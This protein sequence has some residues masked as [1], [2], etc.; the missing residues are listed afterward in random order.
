MK[1]ANKLNATEETERDVAAVI[2]SCMESESHDSS[3]E[4]KRTAAMAKKI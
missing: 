3:C 4:S 1:K 2:V